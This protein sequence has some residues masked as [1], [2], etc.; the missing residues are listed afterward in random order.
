M[1]FFSFLL[2]MKNLMLSQAAHF[3]GLPRA[4]PARVDSRTLNELPV[5]CLEAMNVSAVCVPSTRQTGVAVGKPLQMESLA[6]DR[7]AL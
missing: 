1:Q 3:S 2:A 5:N 4:I 7:L 6:A